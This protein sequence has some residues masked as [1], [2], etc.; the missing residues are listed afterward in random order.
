MHWK[1][2]N[3]HGSASISRLC[4]EYTIHDVV[5]VP[6]TKYRI[7]VYERE[8]D[9]IAL[10]NI[11]FR[12]PEGRVDGTCGLG[13]TEVEALQSAVEGVSEWLSS[14][15]NWEEEDIEWSDS[16]DF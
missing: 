14:R 8:S 2:I 6:G 11:A 16:R 1:Q 7:K 15:A 13:R 3:L 12:T 5:R 4:G 10:P 9:Y